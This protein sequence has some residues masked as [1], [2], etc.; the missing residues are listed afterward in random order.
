ML[1]ILPATVR[2]PVENSTHDLTEV[3]DHNVIVLEYLNVSCL[4]TIRFWSLKLVCSKIKQAGTKMQEI[5]L[6][7]FLFQS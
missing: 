2:C 6:R 7:L 4:L 1:Q 5:L 3:G